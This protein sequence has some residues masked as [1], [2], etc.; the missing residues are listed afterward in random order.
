M[1]AM[2]F[3]AISRTMSGL[4]FT[5]PAAMPRNLSI[6]DHYRLTRIGGVVGVVYRRTQDEALSAARKRVRDIAEEEKTKV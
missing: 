6:S 1:M 5:P 2:Y 3:S 4:E